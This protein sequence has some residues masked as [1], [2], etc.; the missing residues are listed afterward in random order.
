M[1]IKIGNYNFEGPHNITNYLEN[2]SGVYVVLARSSINHSWNVVDIGESTH[3]RNRIENH[4][5]NYCWKKQGF[6][7]LA[8]AVNYCTE[9][10]RMRIEK[11]LRTHF[12]PPCGKQ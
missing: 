6:T 7:S 8:I 2:R 11:E 4:D 1:S 3:I 10:E 5:R 12:D 9:G